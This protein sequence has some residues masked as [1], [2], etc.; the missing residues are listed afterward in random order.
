MNRSALTA[1]ETLAATQHGVFTDQQAAARGVTPTM[2]AHHSRPGGR[3]ARIGPRVYACTGESGWRQQAMA[4]VLSVGPPARASHLSAALLLG[5]D[6]VRP[7]EPELLV[8]DGRAGFGW[9]VHR[10]TR[11]PDDVWVTDGIPH[12]NPLDTLR[13]LCA[14]L[15]EDHLEMA[16]E[17]ALR[18]GLVTLADVGEL[19]RLPRWKG[20]QRLREVL[21]RRP[22]GAPPTGSEL[23]TRAVQLCRRLQLP[24]PIRQFVVRVHGEVVAVLDL[25]WPAYRLFAECDGAVHDQLVALRR[26]RQRQN[27]VVRILGWRP[28]RLTWHD[29]VVRPQTTG[30]LLVALFS[31]AVA[32]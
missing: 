10:R 12:S 29:V 25:A 11:L 21:R 5:L 18:L 14:V 26:D 4:A 3:W 1:V 24:E 8:P 2:L 17:S 6:G 13:D 31:N 22:P 27:D 28:I 16:L 20:V 30:R 32:V 23:E 19:A 7:H 15:D 9:R